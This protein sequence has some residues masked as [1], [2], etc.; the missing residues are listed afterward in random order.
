MKER[1]GK[2][3]KKE[4]Y[5][6]RYTYTDRQ[7]YREREREWGRIYIESRITPSI[8]STWADPPLNL[9]VTHTSFNRL[10]AS[11][12]AEDEVV[13]VDGANSVPAHA[14]HLT[15][16]SPPHLPVQPP[17]HAAGPLS[18][19]T[20]DTYLIFYTFRFF[21]IYIGFLC[22]IS[23]LP[24]HCQDYARLLYIFSFLPEY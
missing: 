16:L 7:I 9:V 18:P 3:T 6:E 24:F 11:D 20:W 13:V 2:K 4:R 23:D 10:R 15:L 19:F 17:C 12:G 21:F 1:K 8:F 5:I 22:P 14:Q